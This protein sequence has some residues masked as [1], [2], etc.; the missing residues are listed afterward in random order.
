MKALL[1]AFA[2]LSF[3]AA[4]TVPYVANAAQAQSTP[5]HKKKHKVAHKKKTHVK[6]AASH[7]KAKPKKAS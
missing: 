4:S 2:L 7:H 5:V 6:K 3:V 1:T